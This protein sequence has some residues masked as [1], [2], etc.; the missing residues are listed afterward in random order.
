M[1]FSWIA[2][3]GCTERNEYNYSIHVGEGKGQIAENANRREKSDI[4]VT[5]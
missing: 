3:Y 1:S 2:A 4:N 5:F